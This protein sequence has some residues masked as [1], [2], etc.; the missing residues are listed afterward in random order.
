M[1]MT[2]RTGS[3]ARAARQWGIGVALAMLLAPCAWGATSDAP[4]EHLV[5]RGDTLYDLANTYLE[6]PLQWPALKSANNVADPQRLVP[7]TVLLIPAELLRKLGGATVVHVSGSVTLVRAG[8]TPEPL[9]AG[10]RLADGDVV[11]TAR[12]GFATFELLDGSLVRATGDSEVVMQRLKYMMRRQRADTVINLEKGRVESSVA[13]QA[14]TGSRFR[15]RTPLMAAGVRGTRFG[16]SLTEEGAMT[17]DVLEG[18]VEL[19]GR[20]AAATDAAGNPPVS[21]SAGQGAAVATRDGV[22]QPVA[23]LA[24][25]D[26]SA[27]PPALQHPLIDLSFS[28]VPGASA[29][30]AYL[31]RDAAIEQVEDNGVFPSARL[32]FEDIDDG[33][34]VVVVR[35]I[36][37]S[38]IEGLPAV[39][40]VRLKARPE[41][42]LTLAPGQD[43]EL[44]SGEVTLQWTTSSG[45]VGYDLQVASDEPFQHIVV[46]RNNLAADSHGLSGLA[47]G[48]YYWRLRSIRRDA[49]GRP[50]AGPYSEARRFSVRRANVPVS[51]PQQQGDRMLF[52][53]DGEPG[54]RYL[55]QIAKDAGFATIASQM[56][57]AEPQADIGELAG[58]EYYLRIQA[59]DSDG[60]VRKFTKPQ[61][62]R[63]MSI[64]RTGDGQPLVAPDGT[65]IERP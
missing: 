2:V 7:G 43:R 14:P 48:V 16:V 63:V 32:R 15:I 37:A 49:A 30:R 18:R 28:D 45:V 59:T 42:P 24:A 33:D 6:D 21:V 54:Q 41:P 12:N 39:R 62:F 17:T 11:K 13:P 53:W 51:A 36:D 38:G 47:S 52:R 61:R 55:L 56:R 57:T 34:Y 60:Y 22:A 35:A 1:S 3:T 10:T 40:A 31:S 46:E 26:L 50:D 25:P 65:A 29:Y 9:L 8:G 64:V 27:I 58:G 20:D 23:L 44:D 4:L 5:V 19:V